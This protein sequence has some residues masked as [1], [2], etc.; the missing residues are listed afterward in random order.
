[1]VGV[2]ATPSGGADHRLD[3]GAQVR[4][5]SRTEAASYLAVHHHRPQIAFAARPRLAKAIPRVSVGTVPVIRTNAL[6]VVSRPALCRLID[7]KIGG[8]REIEDAIEAAGVDIVAH[9]VHDGVLAFGRDTDIRKTFEPFG[10][11]AFDHHPL[12]AQRL[13][14]ETGELALVR[15]ALFR[16]VGQRPGLRLQRRGRMTL[17][18]PNPAQVNAAVFNTDK[19]KP[20]DRLTGVVPGTTVAWSE[21][22]RLRVDYRFDQLWLLLEP[23]IVTE[24]PTEAPEGIVELTR[25][26][27]RERRARRH[28][29]A[30]NAMLDGWIALLVGLEPS[31]RLRAFGIADGVDADFEIVR[32]S[33]FS[34]IG[35]R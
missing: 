34:G 4:P 28:N 1:V 7:C 22:C 18:L 30:A 21:A 19:A 15:D 33:G 24:L 13:I 9:R 12:A 26:F 10:I 31:I 17:L 16:A 8:Y 6:P 25:E 29:R 11:K 14:K 20:V 23:T 27:V 5:P 2:D 3:R 32:T 35:K